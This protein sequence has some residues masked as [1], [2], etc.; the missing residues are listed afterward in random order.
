MERRDRRRDGRREEGD[1]E[2]EYHDMY[3]KRRE[4]E[5]ER[6][7]MCT[8]ESTIKNIKRE[9]QGKYEKTKRGEKD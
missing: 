5:G 3:D 8:K 2:T 6:S 9:I 4:E 7:R 1:G